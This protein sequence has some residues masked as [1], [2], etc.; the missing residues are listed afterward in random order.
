MTY[1]EEEDCKKFMDFFFLITWQLTAGTSNSLV[2]I[3]ISLGY[4]Q[5]KIISSN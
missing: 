1:K 2:Q 4:L 3:N 5:Y